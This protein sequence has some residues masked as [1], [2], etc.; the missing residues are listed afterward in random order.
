MKRTFANSGIKTE[1]DYPALKIPKTEKQPVQTGDYELDALERAFLAGETKK[2]ENANNE[3]LLDYLVYENQKSKLGAN[4]ENDKIEIAYWNEQC[5]IILAKEKIPNETLRMMDFLQI[6]NADFLYKKDETHSDT[7]SS[8]TCVIRHLEKGQWFRLKNGT[9]TFTASGDVYFC[10]YTGNV[11]LCGETRCDKWEV[12]DNLEGIVCKVSGLQSKRQITTANSSYTE[13]NASSYYAQKTTKAPSKSGLHNIG[14]FGNKK[15]AINFGSSSGTKCVTPKI[16]EL[17]DVDIQTQV[18]A[19]NRFKNNDFLKPVKNPF[20]DEEYLPAGTPSYSSGSSSS[21]FTKP[22]VSTS[23]K[24]IRASQK[25][26]ACKEKDVNGVLLKIKSNETKY[27]DMF[28]RSQLFPSNLNEIVKK[29]LSRDEEEADNEIRQLYESKRKQQ[30]VP[31]FLDILEVHSQFVYDDFTRLIVPC[32]TLPNLDSSQ[33]ET[34]IMY[35]RNCLCTLW[36]IVKSSPHGEKQKLTCN[37]CIAA[38]LYFLK[39]GFSMKFCMYQ[40]MTVKLMEPGDEYIPLVPKI[41]IED[42]PL[43]DDG[44]PLGPI[45]Q[46]VRKEETIPLF[47]PPNPTES[48]YQTQPESGP[49]LSEPKLESERLT[50]FLDKNE[51]KCLL[52]EVNFIPKHEFLD[53]RILPECYIK[54]VS[55]PVVRTNSHAHLSNVP[56]FGARGGYRGHKGS[57]VHLSNHKNV[58]FMT[59]DK[60]VRLC[61]T[62][63]A[64]QYNTLKKIVPFC[65]KNNTELQPEYCSGKVDIV[66][67]VKE[68]ST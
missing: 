61:Y 44:E 2:E 12:N 59:G 10:Q 20:A 31:D 62:S 57:R 17:D 16:M 7:C 5:R 1:R 51:R 63:I 45:I 6:M 42:E 55:K 56:N 46:Y 54:Q 24:T 3:K 47:L 39:N 32:L 28:I 36:K 41:K 26:Q 8:R 66:T 64:K 40:D 21:Y 58:C 29:K 53:E 48:L 9:R 13:Q 52:V 18:A 38:L 19:M 15:P 22:S 23:L 11:H 33:K 37:A 25:A 30:K 34:A 35:F 67:L 65:L 43:E 68:L 4:H 60:E 14:I 50:W 27:I 49:T